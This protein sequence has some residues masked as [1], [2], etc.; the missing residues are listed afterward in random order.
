MSGLTSG[1]ASRQPVP[2]L[3]EGPPPGFRPRRWGS[4]YVAEHRLRAMRAYLQTLLVTGFG[5]PLLYLFGLGVGLARLIN[6]P[7]GG[8]TYLEF[9]APALLASAAVTVAS[10][11]FSYPVLMGFKWN[12]I[13][14]GMNAAPISGIQIVNGMVISIFVRMFPTVAVYYAFML[15][16][17]AVP[18]WWG[19]VGIFAA[20]LTGMAVGS[21]IMAYTSTIKDDHGQ[22]AII[23]RFILMPMF[24]FSG[25]FF[26][27]STLPI[28][29][30]WIGWISPLW[31]GTQLGR[32]LS[33][34][35]VE[36][37]WL[38]VVH[39]VYLGGLFAFGWIMSGRT[40][41][42]RLNS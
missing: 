37:T 28:Y 34:G 32:V 19:F 41:R 3:A 40:F 1:A 7:V 16:F 6:A 35:L 14:F 39:V 24:L 15:V 33:Y 27:I 30:Q 8:A 13:F 2:E 17:G 31:H 18:Q 4:F 38:T 42:K 12:P 26:P 25:T 10:E 5:N 23:Q 36:P 20:V 22:M 21:C 11:E 29:L 9:V